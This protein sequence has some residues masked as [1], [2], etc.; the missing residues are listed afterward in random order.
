MI[1]IDKPPCHIVGTASIF[2]CKMQRWL[3]IISS[4]ISECYCDII[5]FGKLWSLETT[6]ST[7]VT[8]VITLLM[9]VSSDRYFK[10][11]RMWMGEDIDRDMKMLTE[12]SKMDC[13][14]AYHC[15]SM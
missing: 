13:K 6:E 15:R 10:W 4:A 9:A 14:L 2:L 11:G 5:S 12:R 7:S 3:D 1:W 8:V